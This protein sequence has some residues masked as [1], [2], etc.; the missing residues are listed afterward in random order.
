MTI[1]SFLVSIKPPA[2]ITAFV[3]LARAVGNEHIHAN[4][5]SKEP[6]KRVEYIFNFFCL[7]LFASSDADLRPFTRALIELPAAQLFL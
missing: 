2:A 5:S 7:F 1:A 6:H 4:A 3:V